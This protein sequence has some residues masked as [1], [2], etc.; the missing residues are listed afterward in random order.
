MAKY[1]F[2]LSKRGDAKLCVDYVYIVFAQE[3]DPKLEVFPADG[4]H[5]GRM[6]KDPDGGS[7]AVAGGEE[8]VP[9]MVLFAP[10][11]FYS[12]GKYEVRFYLKGTFPPGLKGAC[13]TLQV[14]DAHGSAVFAE[15]KLL[16][17]DFPDESWKEFALAFELRQAEVLSFHVRYEGEG[18]FSVKKAAISVR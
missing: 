5:I 17:A 12:E 14:T 6:E 9:G 18:S 16:A 7:F 1:R 2:L 8:E 11:R 3:S 13:A 4:P 15:K 10:T